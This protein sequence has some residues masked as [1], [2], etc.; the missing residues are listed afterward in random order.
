MPTIL[1]KHFDQDSNAVVFLFFV[2]EIL[3]SLYAH[4]VFHIDTI[5]F[6]LLIDCYISF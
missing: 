6:G 1:S 3:N 5:P 2:G 4:T